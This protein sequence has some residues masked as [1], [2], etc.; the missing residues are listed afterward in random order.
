MNYAV[1]DIGTL[2][3]KLLIVSFSPSGEMKEEHFSNVLTCFG[4]SMDDNDGKVLEVNL[5][6][7]VD[8]LNRC[9]QLLTD[10]GVT[11]TRI[12]STH[13]LRRAVNKKEILERIKREVGFEVENISQEEEAKFFF[14]AA[15]S[16]FSGKNDYAVVDVGGGSV[17][18]LIGNK[19]KLKDA[20]FLQTGAQYLH[21]NF[22]RNPGIAESITT[23]E[24]LEKMRRYILEQMVPVKNV[25]GL[26]IIYGSSNIIDLMKAINIP[27]EVNADSRTH[28]YRVYA[29]TLDDFIKKISHL[30][31]GAREEKFPFQ[32][33]Y[34][35]GIDKAFL[36]IVTI[37]Q[38]FQSPYI[39][40]SNANI[41]KGLIYEM[42]DSA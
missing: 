10:Y 30:S 40:P 11:K 17:Q 29:Q 16:S 19:T 12:V 37:A 21:D 31:Y 41:A 4:C 34:M 26:P 23:E 28:P 5:K 2:K 39:V 3:V 27:L 15:I 22:T 13:A 18:V 36:N 33:G 9:K 42:R 35:W 32:P 38:R 14:N 8:E 6:N 25:A 24:D 7:T 20:Y 1:I